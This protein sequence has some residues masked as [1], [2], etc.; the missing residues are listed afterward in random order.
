MSKAAKD[1][2]PPEGLSNEMVDYMML[3]MRDM[4]IG[5]Y[6]EG[7][8]NLSEQF[9]LHVAQE[10]ENVLHQV[11]QHALNVSDQIVEHSDAILAVNKRIKRIEAD[12]DDFKKSE[13]A[14]MRMVKE[15]MAEV[16]Q[17]NQGGLTVEGKEELWK[18]IKDCHSLLDIFHENFEAKTGALDEKADV[19]QKEV[20]DLAATAQNEFD[21]QRQ[22]KNSEMQYL[23]GKMQQLETE[24]HAVK[25][26]SPNGNDNVNP[27]LTEAVKTYFPLLM[28][29]QR[30]EVKI[31]ALHIPPD[32]SAVSRA[33]RN[34]RLNRKSDV[35]SV[36]STLLTQQKFK[37]HGDSSLYLRKI[38]R[39]SYRWSSGI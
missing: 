4:I 32:R 5:I 3:K 33:M 18:Q 12:K 36:Y 35:G 8:G 21:Q 28:L 31:A 15:K 9:A 38:S 37:H 11:D 24:L 10:K 1:I 13:E 22:A 2:T 23:L 25:A 34:T 27:T 16:H 39:Y 30:A 7:A 14:I 17:K 19:I 29:E 26:S 6:N 20:E